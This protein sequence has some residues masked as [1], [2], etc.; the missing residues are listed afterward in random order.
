MKNLKNVI[1]LSVSLIIM[2]TNSSE[3]QSEITETTT[4]SGL[5]YK[6]IARGTGVQAKAGDKVSVHYVGTL[7]DGK[8]FDSSRD[9]GAPFSFNLGAGQVIRGW[10]EGIALLHVGDK[11]ILTIP[12]DLGYGAQAA[13]SIPANSTLIFEVELMDVKEKPIIK[14]YDV[15]GKDT[16]SL[17]DGL[18]MIM[19]KQGTGPKPETGKTVSVHYTGYLT[20]GT[21][22]DSSVERGEPIA[23]PLGQGRVIKGWDMGIAAL[24]TGSQARLIIPYSLGYGDNG[25]PPVIPAKANLIFDVEL[26]GIQ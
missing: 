5:K 11:A 1:L 17:Q 4:S 20:D 25:Y 19:V 24:N 14:P 12:P 15:A 13:G 16:I 2:Q 26:V 9:R 6:I 22:F 21:K 23:F 7:T 8:K 3:A 10:D 18:Q